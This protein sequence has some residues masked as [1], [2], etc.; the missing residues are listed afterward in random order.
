MKVR[1]RK[2]GERE[3]WDA[4]CRIIKRKIKKV[5]KNWKK[6]RENR[7]VYMLE[8]KR[9]RELCREKEEKGREK[10]EKEVKKL[11]TEIQI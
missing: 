1:K 5:Y 4:E 11:R 9:F 6:G 7:E 10:L 8:R 3:W 2:V